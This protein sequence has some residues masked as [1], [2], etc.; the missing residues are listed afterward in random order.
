MQNCIPLIQLLKLKLIL[1]IGKDVEKPR[2]A[3]SFEAR[4]WSFFRDEKNNQA[5]LDIIGNMKALNSI[6]IMSSKKAFPENFWKILSYFFTE[7]YESCIIEKC[8]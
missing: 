5:A 3:S 4:A 2:T 7:V 8:E 1:H 6:S